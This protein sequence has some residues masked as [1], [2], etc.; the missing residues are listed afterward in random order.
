MSID[1]SIIGSSC[2]LKVEEDSSVEAAKLALLVDLINNNTI[3]GNALI[4]LS[5]SAASLVIG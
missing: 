1:C 2:Q 5:L 4:G 3:V